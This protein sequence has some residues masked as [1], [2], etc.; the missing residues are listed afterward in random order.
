MAIG[1][2]ELTR[3]PGSLA[4]LGRIETAHGPIETP[5]FLPVGTQATVKTLTPDELIA[6]GAQA[7]LA[8]TYHLFLRPGPDLIE[9]LGGLHRF[10]GWTGP[11][12]TDSGGYQA[13]SLGF[14]LEHGVG[15]IAKMFPGSAEAPTK[16]V[17]KKLARIDEN[18]VVFASHLDG[19][20]QVLT[21][22]SSIRVQQQLGSDLVL[23]FDEC[24]SPLSSYAYTREALERTHRWAIRCLDAWAAGRPGQGLYG[25]VQGGAYSDLREASAAFI[26]GL[27]FDGLAIGGSLGRS[28]SDM[29]EILEWTVPRLPANRPR[30]L[31]GIGDP[32]DLMACVARGIDTFDCVA[33][34]RLAR[35]GSLYTAQGRLNIQN[36]AHRQSTEPIEPGCSCYTCQTFDRAYLRH[37]FVAEEILGYRL[38]TIHN[39]HFILRLMDRIRQSIGEGTFAPSRMGPGV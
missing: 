36:A 7:I 23:A 20:R 1:F 17:K 27:P 30:H 12:M 22:E 19:S 25:I 18:G 9:Q 35:H 2:T 32:E 38:A 31:L 34:T 39:L 4:R 29:H 21:P 6:L 26:G 11:I 3:Q 10:M 14:A 8:N 16:P 37:L 15:K 24:T 33:P 28:K 13:F 5:A